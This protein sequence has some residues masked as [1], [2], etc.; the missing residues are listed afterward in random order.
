MDTL[1]APAI[2][3]LI[4][5]RPEAG[6]FGVSRKIFTDPAVFE[7]ERHAIFENNWVFVGLESQL[8]A[9]HDFFTTH[10]GR[11]PV[12][13]TRDSKGKLHC[14]LNSCRHRGMVVCNER[15]G[16]RKVHVCRYHGWSYASS[17]ENLHVSDQAEGRYPAWFQRDEHGLAP[18]ARFES[19]RGFLF[20]SLTDDVPPLPEHL[21]DAR[22][23][24]DLIVDQSADG[25][26]YVPGSISY[27]FDA[28]WKLQLENALDMYHFS[29]THASY[30]DL[31]ARRKPDAFAGGVPPKPSEAGDQ[32]TFSFGRGHAVMWRGKSRASESL[33]A[34]RREAY[35]PEMSETAA[36][37]A[38]T[39]RNLTIFPNMRS[40]PL[41]GGL[42]LALMTMPVIVISG[43][44]AIKAVPPSI[45]DG[46]MALGASPVQVVFHHVLPLALPGILT[47]TIIGVAHALGET[48]PLLLIGM[49]AFVAN[50]PTTPLDPSNAL[51]VQGY[52]WLDNINRNF[53]EGYTSALFVV[54]L[55]FMLL[56]NGLAIWLR[57]RFE[58]RW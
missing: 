34:R 45:R 23:F 13:V 2:S 1:S 19:Y 55:V 10:I 22:F 17:G 30:V 9:E 56:L 15:S 26:E 12:L 54:L 46:A 51:P 5:D 50:I 52:L 25:L 28:N 36:R 44:N 8:R 21:G 37:W 7:H 39:A 33:L 35:A 14:L 4:D 3:R 27:T 47:G 48:A 38:T 29:Y 58:R 53:L 6:I 40:A 31:L 49:S 16:N 32:G 20:A 43:R 41:I 57:R 42:T 18:V 24:L 11:Q